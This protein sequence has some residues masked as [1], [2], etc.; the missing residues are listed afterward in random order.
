MIKGFG[1]IFLTW[2]L[3]LS[4][5][6]SFVFYW[7][8]NSFLIACNVGQGD[9]ILITSGFT[10]VLVDGGPNNQVLQCLSNN[11]P[12]W[13]KQIEL[14]VNTHPEADHFSGLKSVIERYTVKQFVSNNLANSSKSFQEFRQLVLEKEIP[15]YTPKVGDEIKIG[16][17]NF[18]VLWP[19]DQPKEFLVWQKD[20]SDIL[21]KIS[22]NQ[23]KFNDYSVV[24]L[25]Q[26]NNFKA[27]LTGDIDEKIE[28]KIIDQNKIDNL[29]I[30]KVAHHGSKYST[31]EDFL[32][33]IQPKTA[34]ISVGK[35][36]WG[37]PTKEV[38]E[39]LKKY[40]V[41]IFRTDEQKDIKIRLN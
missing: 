36:P 37:H 33:A 5:L 2:I 3:V 23:T 6:W 27:L 21:G 38:L 12:F 11:M 14:V 17:L 34:I 4:V 16:G 30:L 31:S 20:T 24:L 25:F 32:K 13:D 35:N 41:D 29:D 19:Q 22:T 26:F 7:P 15:V 40:N 39:R 18:K 1:K 8:K 28:K 9:A 10:Q